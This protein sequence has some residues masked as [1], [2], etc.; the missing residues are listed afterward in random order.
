[1]IRELGFAFLR[2][3]RSRRSARIHMEDFPL[4]DPNVRVPELQFIPAA[5]AHQFLELD[6]LALDISGGAFDDL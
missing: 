2:F 5:G 6:A 3:G 1:M 4:P